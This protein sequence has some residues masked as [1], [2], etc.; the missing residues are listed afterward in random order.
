MNW[1]Q[2]FLAFKI[3]KENIWLSVL[4]NISIFYKT[5]LDTLMN[6]NNP[7]LSI[8]M[9]LKNILDYDEYNQGA[10]FYTLFVSLTPSIS[11][12]DWSKTRELPYLPKHTFFPVWSVYNIFVAKSSL[13]IFLKLINIFTFIYWPNQIRIYLML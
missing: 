7:K 6:A 8:Q 12:S 10:F 5:L 2:L 4:C 1:P 9:T 11:P 13:F 3:C